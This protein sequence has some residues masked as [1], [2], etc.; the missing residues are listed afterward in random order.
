MNKK[1]MICGAS[2]T[3]KTTLARH[4]SGRYDMPYI[5]T[6]AK[7]LWDKYGI[8]THKDAI[9]LSHMNPDVGFKYQWDVLRSR[10]K[11]LDGYDK[12]VVDRSYIDN[13]T[14]LMLQNGYH[15]CDA[16]IKEMVDL[17]N[18]SLADI[19]GIIFL[20]FTPDIILENDG[21]RL[22]NTYYQAMVDQV[23]YWIMYSDKINLHA[24]KVLSIQVWDFQKRIELVEKWLKK[25]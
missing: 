21:A 9:A 5:T 14:Y 23:M 13:L 1:I 6:S 12:Y 20:R 18:E 4:I 8:K 2:G 11:T 19:D 25:L 17:V 3:G 24:W 16:D 10:M 15:L 22:T 7:A